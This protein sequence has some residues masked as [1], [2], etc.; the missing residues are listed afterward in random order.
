MKIGHNDIVLRPRFELVLGISKEKALNT[1]DDTNSLPFEL[2]RSDDRIFI[3]FNRECNHFWSPQLH[4]EFHEE[5]HNSC[6]LFGLFGPN[7]ALWT[8]F[9]FLHFGVATLF[10]IL[11]IQAYT[12][13]VLDYPNIAHLAGMFFL[14][15]LWFV[16]YAF[17]RT[18]KQKG[19]PQM[20]QLHQFMMERVGIYA[21]SADSQTA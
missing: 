8:F 21:I 18:G 19:K 3:T 16:L 13:A 12:R 11:A 17:G 10:I 5:G 6:K 14:I 9:I 4:L 15:I 2:K 7:P 20:K 1:F